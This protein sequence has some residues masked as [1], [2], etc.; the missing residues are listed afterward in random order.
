[1]PIP[2]RT[3][4]LVLVHETRVAAEVEVAAQVAEGADHVWQN[5]A[6]ARVDVLAL[7]RE[8]P[9]AHLG[10]GLLPQG[11]HLVFMGFFIHASRREQSHH[12]EPR[13]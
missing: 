8:L 9:N 10:E 2:P 1:M 3:A 12:E 6:H 5:E 13:H 4:Y 7:R 11:F